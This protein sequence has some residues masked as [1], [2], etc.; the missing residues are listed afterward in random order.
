MVDQVSKK[1][2]KLQPKEGEGSKTIRVLYVEDAAVIRDTISRLLGLSGYEV[3]YAKNGKEGLE[4]A[5]RWK[6]DLV[7]MDL[8]MPVMDGYE[9]IN[10]LKLHAQTR[11]IPVFVV[12][13]WSG[14]KERNQAKLAGAD[15]FFEKPP[16]L[17]RLISAIEKAVAA[18]KKK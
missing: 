4:M 12:S 16:D 3:A 1:L 14:K 2:K 10:Q 6:P 8:R 18:S 5:L 17:H 13:A 7:L 9:A 11:N 15:E